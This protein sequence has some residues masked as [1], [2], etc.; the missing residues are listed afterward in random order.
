M[1]SRAFFTLFLF[2]VGLIAI[3]FTFAD[4]KDTLENIKKNIN[5][6]QQHG[7]EKETL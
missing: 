2:M 7:R 1:A 4:S 3:F 6:I 5:Q